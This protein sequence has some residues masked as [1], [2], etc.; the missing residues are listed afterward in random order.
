VNVH[1]NCLGEKEAME[2][3]GKMEACGVGLQAEVEKCWA[4]E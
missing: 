2:L 4:L 3:R 1:V